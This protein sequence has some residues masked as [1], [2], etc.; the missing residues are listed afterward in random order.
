M[1]IGPPRRYIL[2]EKLIYNCFNGYGEVKFDK[3]TA[4][5]TT[6]EMAL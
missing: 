6:V 2:K 1:S 3:N 4:H 5:Q